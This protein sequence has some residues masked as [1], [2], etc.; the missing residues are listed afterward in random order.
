[1]AV[2]KA[3]DAGAKGFV[4]ALRSKNH[5]S[6]KIGGSNF[7]PTKRVR[8]INL[9]ENYRHIGPW[10]IYDFRQVTNWRAVESAIHKVFR[11]KFD[12]SVDGTREFFRIEPIEISKFFR[13]LQPEL[14][15]KHQKIHQ[16]FQDIEFLNFLLEIFKITG[17]MN[18]LHLQG[19]WTFSLFPATVGGRYYTLNIGPHEVAFS[20][21]A[22]PDR[23]SIHMICTD[24]MILDFPEP[25][26]WLRKRQG[27]IEAAPYR[28]ALEHSSLISF[29]GDFEDAR[30]FLAL[31]GVRRSIMAYWLDALIALQNDNRE[32][33]YK[34][35]HN[36]NAIAALNRELSNPA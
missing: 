25:I 28:T 19:A 35:F 26:A 16:M 7:P 29:E 31:K 18:F 32:S 22:R 14:L 27:G 24:Q 17:L 4:Y 6:I 10:E 23:P 9:S 20:T 5:N 2:R 36:W 15:V 11:H 21:L 34:R 30:Q 1:M 33:L 12:E 3:P 8:E 13:D